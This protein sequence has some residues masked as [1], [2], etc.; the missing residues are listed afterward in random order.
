MTGDDVWNVRLPGEFRDEFWDSSFAVADG[1][2]VFLA[3]HLVAVDLKT[4]EIIWQ[5]DPRTTRGSHC[6][7]V[8]WN[9]DGQ[10]FVV[11]NVGNSETICV[12]PSTGEELWRISSEAG[13]ATPVI[14]DDLL[15][16]YGDSRKKGVAC[17]D[18]RAK[19]DTP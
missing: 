14:Q 2:A 10:E 7:P 1:L 9:H 11:V 12:K 17:Y 19:L 6:S 5:G 15:I 18:L 4:G 8:V 3:G 16:T 13:L